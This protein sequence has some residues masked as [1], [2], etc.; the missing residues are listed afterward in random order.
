MIDL[1]QS[2]TQ[3]GMLKMRIADKR[4]DASG[5]YRHNLDDGIKGASSDRRCVKLRTVWERR[6]SMVQTELGQGQFAN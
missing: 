5:L 1:L 4:L 6:I 2:G 3:I